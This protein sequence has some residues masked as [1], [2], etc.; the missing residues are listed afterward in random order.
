LLFGLGEGDNVVP[1][2][3]FPANLAEILSKHGNQPVCLLIIGLRVGPGGA[4]KQDL[5]Q[6]IG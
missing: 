6:V 2:A 4:G 1:D 5:L 3:A